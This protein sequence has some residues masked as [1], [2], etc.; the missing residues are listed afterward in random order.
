MTAKHTPGPWHVDTDSRDG[1]RTVVL[2]HQCDAICDTLPGATEGDRI[3][4]RNEAEANARLIAAAP[5][6]LGALR[7]CVERI[8][9]Y[10]ERGT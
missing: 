2:D 10:Q 6:L 7:L 9:T 4:A 1:A 3:A 5:E 8:T